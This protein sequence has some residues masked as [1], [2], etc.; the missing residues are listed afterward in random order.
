MEYLESPYPALKDEAQ[1]AEYTTPG[2]EPSEVTTLGARGL[3]SLSSQV[4]ASGLS[5]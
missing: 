1:T 2:T 4:R 3:S 5:E